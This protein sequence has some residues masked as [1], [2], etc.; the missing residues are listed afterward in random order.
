MSER[1][2]LEIAVI[3]LAGR[4]P[5]ARSVEELWR[6]L[7]A[8][9]ESIGGFTDQ[10]LAAAGVPPE[11]LSDPRYVKAGAV[12]EDADLLDAEFFSLTPREAELI[13]PQHR[14]FLECAWEALESAG[15]DPETYGRPIGVYAGASLSLYA[16]LNVWSNR[17]R[18]D[19]LGS[20]LGADKDH[21]STLVSWKLNLSGPSLAVQS[22]CSTSLVAVHLAV[23]GLLGGEC[24]MALA[25]GVS[26]RFPQRAG[27]WWAEGGIV[28]PDGHCRA[29]D[30]EAGGTVFGNGLGLVVLKRLEDA[31]AD[32]D[33][34]H[35]V[36]KGSAINNDGAGR[37]SYT[38]PSLAGQARVIRAAQV[39]AEVEPDTIGYVEAHGTGTSLGDPIEVSALTEAFRAG[40]ERRGFC[41]L[42]SIKTNL[43]HLNAA[44]GIA[45]FIK[46]VLALE[47]RTI[48]PSLHL[49]RPNPEIDFASS[50]FFVSSAPLAWESDN[51]PRRA[52]VSSFGMG[53]TNAH[54]ILEEAPAP[55][56]ASSSR[57]IQ[58]LVLSARSAAALE[59]ATDRLA[60]HLAA[61]PEADL[62]DVAH[63]LHVGRR[64]FGHRRVALA[65]SREEAI[66]ALAE[67]DPRRVL[68]AA[69]GD[70]ERPV[71]FLF[72]GQG[73]QHVD[74]A[75]GLYEGEPAFRAEVDRYAELLEPRLGFDLR[76][77]LFPAPEQAVAA[78]ERLG[79]TAV[80]QPALFVIEHALARLWMEWGIRP[81]AMLGHS[82]GEYVAACLAGVFSL[83]DALALVALRG[84]LIEDLPG[85]AMLAVPLPAERLEPLLG[86]R[87]S[88]AAVN[89]PAMCVVSG[90]GEDVERLQREVAA[91]LP[92]GLDCRPLYTSHAFHSAALEAI[93]P[94]FLEGVRQV[95]LHAPEIPFVSN[96][97]GGWIT[98]AEAADPGYWTRHL[99]QTVR[100]SAGLRTLAASS[101]EGLLLEVGPGRTLT[102]L[103]RQNPE[104]AARPVV[105]S[106]RHPQ[107]AGPDQETLLRAL[108]QLWLAGAP[109][110]WRAFYA[111]ERRR[112]IPL[113]TYPFERRRY[114]LEPGADA[115]PATASAGAAAFERQGAREAG[116]E[117]VEASHPRPNLGTAYAAPRTEVEREIAAVWRDLFGIAEV[118]IH[119]DFFDLG[120]HSILVTQLAFRVREALGVE[121]PLRTF[122]EQRTVAGLAALVDKDRAVGGEAPLAHVAH[123]ED[124]PPSFAQQRLWLLDQL[125]PGNP[126]YNLAM[127]LR[128]TGTLV[129][130]ALAG[131]LREVVRRHET[132]RT[133]FAS[134]DGRPVQRVVP[135][136]A[137]A[138]PAID[139]SA[140]SS[141]AGQEEVRRLAAE[142]ARQPFD[143]TRPPLLR[144]SLLR[145]GEREHVLLYA[146]HHIVSDGWS[147]GVLMVEVARLYAAFAA[148]DPSPLPELPVQYADFAAW[149]RGWLAGEVL[150]SQCAYW[151]ER[152]AGAPTVELPTDRPRPPAQ[153]FR[154]A[155]WRTSLPAALSSSLSA[156]AREQGVSLFMVLL[157]G[158][159]ALVSRYTGLED[160]VVGTPIA[161]RTRAELEGLIGFFV[162]TLVLRT[163]LS[164][165]PMAGE[166]LSRVR[167]TALGAYA[168]QDLP[169]E[170]LV[171]E[172]QPQRDLSRNPLFQLMFNLLSPPPGEVSAG[173][174]SVSR[175]ES[176]GS[177][178]LFD[179]Q[180]YLLETPAGIATRWEYATGLFELTT[181]ERWSRHFATLLAGIAASP[182]ARLSELPLLSAPEREQLLVEWNATA[183]AAPAGCIHEWIAAQ[184]KRTPE[185]VAVVFGSEALTYGELDRRSNGLARHLG[186]LGVGPEG[187]VGVALERSLELVIGLL[188]VLKAGGAYVPLDP[189]Y[190]A[191]RLAF[192]REDAELK[193]VLSPET[194]PEIEAEVTA[195]ETGVGPQNAAYIIYTSGS[196]GRPKGVQIPHGAL[197]NFLISMAERPGLGPDD[198]LLAVTSLSFD[199][200]GLELYLPL[201]VGGWVV[202]ASREEAS[203]GRRLQERIA[204]C[205]AT[206]LQA[207]PA[208]WRL[209]LDA[210]WQGGE[211]LK[212]LC[213]GEALPPSLAASLLE[214]VG[215]L[216]NVY[217]PTETTV[218]STVEEVRAAE[219]ISIGRPVANTEAYVV[220]RRVSPVPVGS[221][222]ELYLG[223]AGLARGYL[224]RP[225][226]TAERFVPNPFGSPGSRLYRT[227]DLARFRVDGR[228]ECLGRIDHQ[229]KVRGFRIEL[230]EIEASLGRHPEVAAAVVVARAEGNDR[231][232]VAYVVPRRPGAELTDELR[233]GV[234]RSLPEYMVPTAWVQLASLPLTPTGKVDRKALPAPAAEA[235]VSTAPRTPTEEVLAS[236]WARVLGTAAVGTEDSFFDRGG[237]SLLAAQLVSR[238]R[239]AFGVELPLRRIFE[240]PTLAAQARAIDGART[241][242]RGATAAPPLARVPRPRNGA[243]PLSFAQQR[244]WFLS[245]LDPDSPAYNMSAALRLSGRLD[246][247]AIAATLDEIVRRH[248]VLRTTF[249]DD[250][251]E[252]VQVIHP[253]RS[254]GLGLVDLSGVA[255][256][257]RE[258]EVRSLALEDL[259]R[260]FDLERGPLL[261]ATLVRLEEREHVLL[262]SMHHV[263]SDGWSLEVLVREVGALYRAFVLREPVA[264][265]ELK[266]QYADYALWQRSWLRGEVLDQHVAYWRER[267]AG[268]PALLQLP[269]DRPRPAVQRFRGARVDA[270]LPREAQAWLRAAAQRHGAT[271]FMTLL[272]AFAVL[273]R[274][275]AGEDDVVVGTPTA[276]RDR[277]E[278][279]G[280]IGFFVNTLALRVDASGGPAFEDLLLRVRETALD[281]YAHQEL[282]FEKLVDELRPERSLSHSPVFQVMLALQNVPAESL[283]LPGLTLRGEARPQ[284]ISKFDL[285]LNVNETSEGLL[286]QWRYN[287]EL[288]DRATMERMAERLPALVAGIVAEPQRR[289]SEL[290]L[291]SAAESRQLADW[292]RGE[293]ASETG[294]RCLHE[295]VEAVAARRPEAP[296][297]VFEGGELSYA[298]LNR[299]ANRLARRLR[300]LGVGPEVPVGVCAERSP[301]M[302]AGLI[303]VLKAGGAYVPL[304]PGYPR[305]RFA[306]LLA[307]SGISVLLTQERLAPALPATAAEV[308]LLE[309][310]IDEREENLA[311]AVAPENLAYVIYTS[312]STGTPKGVQVPH[313]GLHNLA[314]AQTRLFAVGADSR[315]LQF[316]SLSFDASV[317]EIAMAFQAGAALCLAAR[318]DLL[319][320]PELI[321]LLRRQRI[322]TVTLPPSA[323]A[324]LAE[325]ELPDLRTLVVAGEA[326]AVDLARR[327]A[328]GRRLV[329]AYGPTEVTVCATAAV[330]DGG[331][332]LP[333]GRP[334]QGMEVFVL[335]DGG[336]PAAAGVPG[337]LLVGGIGLARGYRG[338]ADL[339]AERFV[340]HPFAAAAGARL[341]RT[342]DLVR[343]LPDGDLE[344]LGRI[345]H[346]IKIRGVRVEPG[347]V[348]A[349]L[350]AQP[351][352]REAV[353]VARE[354]GS[355]PA[356][357]VAYAVAAP[358]AD[359]DAAALREALAGSL[360]EPL[361]PS[362]V[363]VLDAL[364]LTPNGKID[365]KALP[366]PEIAR[367]GAGEFVAPRTELERFLAGLW[368][369][370]LGVESVGVHDDFFALGGNSITGAM[371][372][373]RLQR[374]LGEIVHVVVMF[375]APTVAQLASWVAENY[376]QAV[377]RLFGPAALGDAR[378]AVWTGRVDESRVSE[379]RALIPPPAYTS[380]PEEKNPPAVFVLSPPRSGST[381]LRVM[382]G[383]NPRL[384]APPELELLG[385]D[386]LAERRAAFPG[387]NSF[388]LEGATRAVMEVRRC[389]AEE[390][391][392]LLAEM[393]NAGGT[394]W[395]VYRRLQEWIGDRILVDKTPSY[396]LDLSVLRRAEEVFTQAR[397]IHLLRHPYAM[398]RSFE[399]A[400]LDQVFFRHP[401]SFSRRDLAELIWLVSQQN[402]LQFLAEVPPERQL[403]VRFEDLVSAPEAV[404]RGICDFLEVEYHADMAE[405]YKE[406]SARMT[407]GIHA[408]SRMLGDV[409]FHQHSRVDRAAAER[410][411]DLAAEDSLSD[412]T[413][414]MAERLGYPQERR[415]AWTPIEPAAIEPGRPWPLSFAQERLWILD[416]LDPG[417]P[418]YNV[419]TAVRLIGR[420]DPGALARSLT[421]IVRRHTVLRAVFSQVN[422]VPVQI[423]AEPA[424]VPLPVVDLQALGAADREK[425]A[426]RLARQLGRQPFDLERGPMLRATLLRL[427]AEEH[428]ALF[429][430]HHVASDGW[431]MG[432]LI[433][434]VSVLYGAFHEG[435]PAVLPE[436]PVQ[437]LD[438]ARW[439][440]EW[441]TG[442]VLERELAYWRQALAGLEPLQLPTDRPRPPLQTFRGASRS[443]AVTAQTTAALKAMGQHRNATPFMVLLAAFAALLHRYTGQEDLA[444]GTPA[445]NRD[446]AELEGLIGFFVNTLVLRADLAASPSF[447][448]LLERVRGAALGAFAHQQLPF[449]KVVFELQPER[450]LA[451]SPLFQV[452]LALQNAPA[453]TLT[454]ADLELRPFNPETGTAKFDLTLNVV[455]R[456][457][458]FAGSLEYNTDLLDRSTI[459]RVLSHFQRLLERVA[460]TPETRV[461]DLALLS[462]AE[463]HQLVAEWSDSAAPDPAAPCVHEWIERRAERA[464]ERLAVSFQGRHLTYREL[465]ISAES[466]AAKLVSLGVGPEARV[467]VC[468]ERTP[469][470]LASLLA[471]WKAGAA[472][473][474]LDPSYPEERLAYMLEDAGAGLLLADE[475]T[476]S[477]LLERAVSIVRVDE[478]AEAEGAPATPA[479]RAAGDPAH[480]AYLIYTSGSTGRPKG[481]EVAHGALVSFLRS[482]GE[483]PGLK[484]EDAL[485]AVT[486]LSFDI[487]GLE[488][489][490]PLVVG[491]RIELASREVAADGSALLRLLAE[492]GAT[493]M[494]ATPVTWRLLVDAGWRGG[495]KVLCGGEA[496]PE[497]LAAE[498]CARSDSVW[499]LYGPTETTVW[500]AARRVE[501]GD[502]IAVGGPIA[503][504]GLYVLDS[505]LWPV[506]VGVPG[507]LWIGGLGLAR[508]YRNRP[509]LTAE[510]FVPDPFSGGLGARMYDTG[511]LARFRPDGAIDLLG[512]MDHQVKVRGFRIE[513]GEIEA[514]LEAHPGVREAVVVARSDGSDRSDRSVRSLVAYVTGD[515][516]ALSVT[517]LRASLGRS[518]PDYMVPA[519]WVVLDALPL[520][521]NG[522][523]DRRALL[524]SAGERPALGAAYVAPRTPLEELLAGVW[525][526]V[527]RVERVGARDNFFALGGHSL[528]AI[529][530]VSRIGEALEIDVP[531]RRLFEAPTVAGLAEAL[532]REAPSREDLERSAALVLD[533]LRLP[534]EEIDTLLL[535]HAGTP[536]EILEEAS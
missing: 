37:M 506:P 263:I 355:G 434:E 461:G 282:P 150:E 259:R 435:R 23:Q 384:F 131:A 269:A 192:M 341:Y 104:T 367:S 455:E 221:P 86:D 75:R 302:V 277:A 25:G 275:H 338:R 139:L 6:N 303:A 503:N 74:M 364:P 34:I 24:D 233:A 524:A 430:M 111:R 55:E 522:K 203:D 219:A 195:P 100:F 462:S 398:I 534:E 501:P 152:L 101:P 466:L 135:T 313:R 115:L 488:L 112:R 163:D 50:P 512:R 280:L 63:T 310:E 59:A 123:A 120:G 200:A 181:V 247:I 458:G 32:G 27:Y 423:V 531:L 474:P 154:G 453:E 272:A 399:E 17:G 251:R 117:R 49:R 77:V 28:S 519:A 95:E 182:A 177:T 31:L 11:A 472:Y 479:A 21:L 237:H 308:V 106:L 70:R 265:P 33:S 215:S 329:N 38:A 228:L 468:L 362:A 508:G 216:W 290:P 463:R 145:L 288:F 278:L 243:L 464:P 132:L 137:L 383:G 526:E 12:V 318:R 36:I 372:V 136:L 260:P 296:A 297:I 494:Q 61:H 443:F 366:A 3:G 255:G 218:W 365:S 172:L 371:F 420:L 146:M 96:V 127:A 348:E 108:G 279:E 164:G 193:V 380:R 529:R 322:S 180:V 80:T 94:L 460:A 356:R 388:W 321:E 140:L 226:L 160:V 246:V 116:R 314:A 505:G 528:L 349:A 293:A 340:P 99:R 521:P 124:L 375:D 390:A 382:L 206:V 405:P 270:W 41:A 481:V 395:E 292:S 98:A 350:R 332:R 169:F 361:I 29:F 2:G 496:L 57:P 513:L 213:G 186:S 245:R 201:L 346:Q 401:H 187:R 45:G 389:G 16:L 400:K 525:S 48:P 85:G 274:R 507:E 353:A 9:V 517:E 170:R 250:G 222:G 234:R 289:I 238:V 352:V 457:A 345:D 417:N 477:A 151:R 437:Y 300:R 410:W 438:Y 436:L 138:L 317:S 162:N 509:E 252:P 450:N 344:F 385:F 427:G 188:A 149:Q 315:V 419:P 493:V 530:L 511:D 69:G 88:L 491:A 431:S 109:V 254:A 147:M 499:N 391:E 295:M 71:L 470:M 444:I 231:R 294:A 54:A 500:S 476:P 13:D 229:V 373:N 268:A 440:R 209:L 92:P 456:P 485:L 239:D 236:L 248:E 502:R 134:V 323:L 469:A 418:A 143:L 374:E 122:F 473:V 386:T 441:L 19:S 230:G 67:R 327:W 285:T 271:L 408:W 518:L 4:F 311:V 183:A 492:S 175:L 60:V 43:G 157:A 185:T 20:L 217:G 253:P 232:L 309:Q 179:L 107:D 504:T 487:A 407:D 256:P 316:A 119:D 307:D 490:L 79:R 212:A 223:G 158:F 8:G 155:T 97:T 207:T 30:A 18:I 324:A 516:S 159:G 523:V 520:T 379:L 536:D 330:Y 35:A 224:A 103:A 533:L 320:G 291:L 286:C 406:K 76:A 130:G 446:R 267:L 64:G 73:A 118:G 128:L 266:I 381:L 335:D 125:A 343:F 225:E 422:G 227:G 244:L 475:T 235:T 370:I 449:E 51:G 478:S 459:D 334:I 148:G 241:G 87:L 40:T 359:L 304:D 121:L 363:V 328:V 205:R 273:L 47:R 82:I 445:A 166:L 153:S 357:L 53:G 39:M 257:E 331:D 262:F 52:A 194:L 358:G 387:R 337:E 497:R 110:D 174:L 202:V 415:A 298:D 14:L 354:D 484:L 10:E 339:T 467:A 527:L 284:E 432:V 167:E 397:Y 409:K 471:V 26:I 301:E 168:H 102:S 178:A 305:E 242:R 56:P 196:T 333:V 514:A 452:M 93:L 91:L 416:C 342:G 377:V 299:R 22:A 176:A 515:A 198:T 283:E 142:Q 83:E 480:L 393:E 190:P 411:R 424:P 486:S 208:T 191:E 210:G 347:E 378:K 7:V 211:G 68:T 261:R 447:E 495:L 319:P 78:A 483:R 58:M 448:Q 214:R 220:D 532:L 396:A 197:T 161:G 165:D 482:M 451:S 264:L 394:T 489:F 184:A 65:S 44:A 133:G 72:P 404:L 144:A 171:E 105:R 454:L 351:G 535:R 421:E 189:S 402:V 498:L 325:A 156:L 15:Y 326:C 306:W 465:D 276:N 403:R 62:A 442:A 173:E 414:K 204:G 425:E 240:A 312:G 141:G 360:P 89:G 66:R 81:Q 90:S 439:Q 429:S 426:R 249:A 287:S 392:Q 1:T 84:R 336:M 412:A 376:H 369:E 281:A 114:W 113:P 46:T 433:R 258:V 42:G 428:V 199:I 126:F 510:R 129:T 368:Q 413:W 5:G